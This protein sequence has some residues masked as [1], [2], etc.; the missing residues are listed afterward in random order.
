[1]LTLF[2]TV[3]YC[4]GDGVEDDPACCGP[5]RFRSETYIVGLSSDAGD[6]NGEGTSYAEVKDDN[7]LSWPHET[8][9]LFFT[10][11]SVN[12][13]LVTIAY[14][15]EVNRPGGV[16]LHI[17]CSMFTLI[18]VV[19][20]NIPI[21]LLHFL[22]SHIFSS[23]YI[24]FTVI[25]WSGGGL[26]QTGR[27]YIYNI[28]NYEEKPQEA[29]IAIFLMLIVQAYI[30][31]KGWYNLSICIYDSSVLSQMKSHWVKTRLL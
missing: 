3:H 24:F 13:L 14:W 9:W 19:I 26:H 18:E 6:N 8:A 29:I 2:I 15:S 11:A 4:C 22:Y 12:S 31:Y 20:S 5:R 10:I 30:T 7:K 27:P 16:N 23:I 21:C 1:M 25:Y 28:I 17:M